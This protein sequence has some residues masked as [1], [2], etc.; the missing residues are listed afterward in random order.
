MGSVRLA[1][2]DVIPARLAHSRKP[3]FR[4][5]VG[6]CCGHAASLD[7]SAGHPM[8]DITFYD[9][10]SDSTHKSWPARERIGGRR[11]SHRRPAE[12]LFAMF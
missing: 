9:A 12:A 6:V 8:T 5:Q 3:T 2:Y 11:W 4:A 7:L 10:L 1:P